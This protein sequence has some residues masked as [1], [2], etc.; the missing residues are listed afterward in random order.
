MCICL[1]HSTPFDLRTNY[2]IVI[3][4]TVLIPRLR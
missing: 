4:G 2:K 1:L 3:F